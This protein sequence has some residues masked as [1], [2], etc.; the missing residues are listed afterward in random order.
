MRVGLYCDWNEPF[1]DLIF[2]MALTAPSLNYQGEYKSLTFVKPEEPHDFALVFNASEEVHCKPENT[3]VIIFEPIEILGENNPW[4]DPNTHPQGPQ[5]HIFS[6][7]GATQYPTAYGLHLA[8]ASLVYDEYTPSRK[9]RRCSMIC[10][11]KTYTPYHR[12]RREILSA[13][14]DTDLD[15]HFWGRGIEQDDP[16]VKGEITDYLKNQAL[17]DYSYVI[18][19]EN[20]PHN[21][22]T[23]KFIDPIL[24]NAV[25]ITNST[26]A[27]RIFPRGSFRAI[28]F[29]MS[30]PDIVKRITDIITEGDVSYCDLPVSAARSL[31]KN[32]LNICEWMYGHIQAV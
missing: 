1:N 7:C 8:Q 21:V 29:E 13:L 32:H 6:F 27:H 26:I 28:D 19:F 25:P 12:K 18:D 20:S 24:S 16:R 23:D 30:V 2:R 31:I 9:A 10:S 3:Y 15:I 5:A 22:L 17:W 11:Y 14:K 4:L